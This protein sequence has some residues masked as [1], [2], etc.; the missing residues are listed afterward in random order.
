MSE[1]RTGLRALP[2]VLL[3]AFAVWLTMTGVRLVYMLSAKDP[4]AATRLGLISEG[5]TFATE[6]LMIFGALEL[7]RRLTGQAARGMTIALVGLVFALAIDVLFGLTNFM[8]RAWEHEWIYKVWDYTSFTT[9]L[10]VPIG[11]CVACWRERRELGVFIVLVSLLT[12][13]P[14]F[15]AKPMYEWLPN[16][17]TGSAISAVFSCV[18]VGL[19][20]AGFVATARGSAIASRALAAD[21]LRL[22]AR[23]LWLRVIAAVGLVLLT[24]MAMGGS[25]GQGSFEMLKLAMMAG[26]IINLV[27]LTQFGIGAVRA[28]RG[29]VSELGRWPLVLGGG[30]S[31][32]AAGVTLAQL[33]WL[34][35]MLYASGDLD[36]SS[37][38]EYAQALSIALPII[39]GVG[40]SLLAV[41]IAGL[42][43]QR[44]NEA[45]RAQAQASG[46]GFVALTLVSV[47][48]QA[49]M[50]PQAHSMG[51]FAGMSLLAAGAGLV[52]TIMMARLCAAGAHELEGDP[53]LPT[54]SVVS[55]G[56]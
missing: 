10:L 31:L 28:G 18:R 19:L 4:W 53:G 12:W 45:L 14:P 2:L 6:V 5:T 56:T 7:S 26:A 43:A 41:A 1:E 36:R 51:S 37:V 30:A 49:W 27:A 44:G 20:L 42:G 33:A 54:A 32:W 21:G 16:G 47:A 8:A 17:K 46:A 9:W 24:L 23:A 35:K 15:L 29:E 50:L 55:D 38:V 34:Y 48:I 40:V 11:L 25:G 22:A 13:P 52:A 39:V 3:L